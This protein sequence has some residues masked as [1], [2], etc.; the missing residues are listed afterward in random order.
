MRSKIRFL[1]VCAIALASGQVAIAGTFSKEY[2]DLRR[3]VG[4]ADYD[5]ALERCEAMIVQYPREGVLYEGLAEIA[6]YAGR[7]DDAMSFLW[8]RVEDGAGLSMCY[9]ALGNLSYRREDDRNAVMFLG[10]AIELGVEVPECYSAFIYSYERLEG[11]DATLR[12]MTSLCHRHP[13]K[14]GY[15]YGLALAYWVN[16]DYSQVLRHLGEALRIRPLEDRYQHARITV[17]MLNAKDTD[18]GGFVS[19]MIANAFE[20]NDFHGLFLMMSGVVIRRQQQGLIDSAIEECRALLR[21]SE[22]FGYVRWTGWGYKQLADI[23]SVLSQYGGSVEAAERAYLNACV[24][25]DF[26]LMQSSLAR[27]FDSNLELLNLGGAIPCL[28]RRVEA[29][30]TSQSRTYLIGILLDASRLFVFLGQPEV[31]LELVISALNLSERT[32]LDRRLYWEIHS[33]LGNVYEQLG[34]YQSAL[35]HYEITQSITPAEP[36]YSRVQAITQ[37]NLGS[38]YLRMGFPQRA[39]ERFLAQVA[40]ALEARYVRE[41]AYG[42]LNLGKANLELGKWRSGH[43]ELLQAL[44]LS[45]KDSIRLCQKLAL[46]AIAASY[47]ACGDSTRAEQALRRHDSLSACNRVSSSLLVSS[48]LLRDPNDDEDKLAQILCA[49]G[50]MEQGFL[51]EETI[52]TRHQPLW[53]VNWEGMRDDEG[54]NVAISN[55]VQTSKKLRAA[56]DSLSSRPEMQG[57]LVAMPEDALFLFA[58]AATLDLQRQQALA[59]L[60]GDPRTQRLVA[61]RGMIKELGQIQYRLG[62]EEAVLSYILSS[63]ESFACVITRDAIAFCSNLPGRDSISSLLKRLNHITDPS[64]SQALILPPLLDDSD[65][66]LCEEVYRELMAPLEALLS[67]SSRVFIIPPTGIPPIPFDLMVCKSAAASTSN[68]NGGMFLIE[69]FEIC[70]IPDLSSL[71]SKSSQDSQSAHRWIGFGNPDLPSRSR[72][73]FDP[74]MEFLGKHLGVSTRVELAAVPEEI[75]GIKERFQKSGVAFLGANATRT[76]LLSLAGTADVV[77]I[78]AHG[79]LHDRIPWASGL[80]LSGTNQ[81]GVPTVLTAFDIF[82]Y[83]LARKLLVLSGCMSL[84]AGGIWT[85]AGG[86]RLPFHGEVPVIGSWS[87]VDDRSTADLMLRL[88]AHLGSGVSSSMALTM[89]KREIIRETGGRSPYWANFSHIGSPVAIFRSKSESPSGKDD[90]AWLLVGGVALLLV[91]V[92]AVVLV[93]RYSN[94]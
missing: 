74:D 57:G 13:A 72:G 42:H 6:Q 90:W 63:Q 41:A 93:R 19:Q 58:T 23:Y 70:Y 47:L 86:L 8:E 56:V 89:A 11:I 40:F 65:L 54:G 34:D 92:C 14:A 52:R 46:K 16:G 67:R 64:E 82:E 60:K 27:A 51:S 25:G 33:T 38:V 28:A 9:F 17:M 45:E 12:L 24:S 31:A 26:H 18:A 91:S 62:K 69:R 87:F 32:A 76:T 15:W 35:R 4:R 20:K 88:Y 1:A 48:R 94:S 77:H 59:D 30:K 53:A 71:L 2:L 75:D 29:C 7:I 22:K 39:R 36:F 85:N 21:V 43:E 78:A 68:L 10:K 83:P 55:F 50:K 84:K 81:A 37:G 66:K 80:A 79:Y 73:S 61:K 5:A 49:L 44:E 3:M